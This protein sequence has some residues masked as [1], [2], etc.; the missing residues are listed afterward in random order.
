MATGLVILIF[1]PSIGVLRNLILET[2]NVFDSNFP[3][4]STH[5]SPEKLTARPE[6]R[7][8]GKYPPVN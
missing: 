4:L 1:Q 6:N 5:D 7:E 8:N 2:N 3:V